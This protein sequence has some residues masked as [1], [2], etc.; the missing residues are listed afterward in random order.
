MNITVSGGF[1]EGMI[2]Q[3]SVTAHTLESNHNFPDLF[4]M[5][6]CWK[7]GKEMFRFSG[8]VISSVPGQP[9]YMYGPPIILLCRVC[10][11]NH[12]INSIL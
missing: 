8:T 2:K 4:S 6:H 3:L 9:E 1:Q 7:C 12:L 10:K 11:Q 5:F